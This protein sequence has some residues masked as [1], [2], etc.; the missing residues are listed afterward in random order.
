MT[1][2]EQCGATDKKKI[3]FSQNEKE[4]IFELECLCGHRTDFRTVLLTDEQLNEIEYAFNKNSW[5]YVKKELRKAT[6]KEGKK[7]HYIWSDRIVE[8]AQEL[9]LTPSEVVEI[10]EF[11]NSRGWKLGGVRTALRKRAGDRVRLSDTHNDNI[12]E[13]A[14]IV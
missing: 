7:Y 1:Q 5:G 4:A 14:Y 12:F 9:Q 10:I 8:E 11:W 13:K 3:V 2:C 6:N